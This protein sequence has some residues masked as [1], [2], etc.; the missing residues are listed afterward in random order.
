[1][2]VEA[3]K[4]NGTDITSTY[5]EKHKNYNITLENTLDTTALEIVTESE[6]TEINTIIDG[7][8]HNE[9]KQ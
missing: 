8:E 4:V 2:N 6:K 7:V 1:M 9:Q 5:D 3:I